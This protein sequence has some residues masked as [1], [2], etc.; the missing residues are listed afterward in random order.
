MRPASE[1][2]KARLAELFAALCRIPSPSGNERA[3]ADRVLAELHDHPIFVASQYHPEFKSRPVRPAP[4]F[5]EFVRAA[6]R[7]A[8]D[9]VV[10]VLPRAVLGHRLDRR[11]R[12]PRGQVRA[13]QE[14]PLAT[15]LQ[16]RQKIARRVAL[17]LQP[18][19][20]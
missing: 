3:C 20:A 13:Q 19:P 17:D 14:R 2:E 5:R 9:A 10:G 8:E 4:L 1:A 11:A 12:R 16:P 7:R 15:A 18:Q 6:L